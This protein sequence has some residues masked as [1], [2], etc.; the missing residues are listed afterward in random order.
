MKRR[1]T[2]IRWYITR[3]AGRM[4]RITKPH[5]LVKFFVK[6]YSQHYKISWKDSEFELKTGVSF[7]DFF[8]R[9]LR[10][11]ARKLGD[12]LVAPADS[13]ISSHG[14]NTNGTLI[15]AKGIDFSFADLTGCD[16]ECPPT[17]SYAVF[18]L[19]PAD[20]HRFHAPFDM[21]IL[22]MKSIGGTCYPV[23][24]KSTAKRRGL[25]CCNERVVLS[26][27]STYGKYWMVLVGAMIVGSVHLTFKGEPFDL[28]EGH[29]AE[30]YYQLKIGDEIGYFSMGSTVVLCVESPVLAQISIPLHQKIKMGDTLL[31]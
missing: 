28:S 16:H 2:I 30:C 25:Y 15:Q 7:H 14:M 29:E 23:H 8:T 9:R 5:I 3:L 19:S 6:R 13:R 12:K 24:S 31:Q 17:M 4:S 21:S 22:R 11:G 26:G 1:R 18:Y 20:Y 10:P 27:D